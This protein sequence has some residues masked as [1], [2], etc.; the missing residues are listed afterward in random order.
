MPKTSLPRAEIA[1]CASTSARAVSAP[2]GRPELLKPHT[3]IC[4]KLRLE[5]GIILL[6][7]K[8][9]YRG[10]RFRYRFCPFFGQ[11][12][13][14]PEQ[15]RSLAAR[16]QSHF[17]ANSATLTDL[18]SAVFADFSCA[19]PHDMWIS[20]TAFKSAVDCGFEIVKALW[21]TVLPGFQAQALSCF[22]RLWRSVV[23]TRARAHAH[24]SNL[25]NYCI[26]LRATPDLY[27]F[28]CCSG[29]SQIPAL[30]E[31]FPQPV[32]CALTGV[33][34][35]GD[36]RDASLGTHGL[37]KGVCIRPT[38]RITKTLYLLPHP[39]RQIFLIQTYIP[40]K[41]LLLLCKLYSP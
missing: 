23:L 37:P 4:F 2:V 22:P 32:K 34:I 28:P 15:K 26:L 7:F 38:N 39:D 6:F 11:G 10:R 29:R 31:F 5:K 30:I 36:G 33:V 3:R 35:H 16:R 1:G 9:R 14:K 21:R 19:N 41:T 24:A 20:F 25:N 27:S 12:L 18:K 13:F 40:N 8:V 17:H